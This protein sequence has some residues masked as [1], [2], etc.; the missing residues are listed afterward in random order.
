[1]TITADITA[2]R[3]KERKKGF[4][5]RSILN[6]IIRSGVIGLV[7]FSPLAFGSVHTWAFTTI[8]IIILVLYLLWTIRSFHGK[9]GELQGLK[10]IK[11]PLNLPI[12]LFIG[13]V[14]FQLCPLPSS[15]LKIISPTTYRLY[16]SVFPNQLRDFWTLSIYPW[17]TAQE[18]YR[19]LAYVGAFYLV[20]YHFR[21]KVWLDRLI[22]AI[23]VTGFVAATLGILQHF[24]TPKEIYGFRDASYAGPFGPYVNRNHFAGYME[25][26]ILSGI[27]LLLSQVLVLRTLGERW[28]VYLSEWGERVFKVALVGFSVTVMIV[29]LALSLSR[30]GIISL[31]VALLFMANM[32]LIRQRGPF[33]GVLGL[34]LAFA[35]FYLLWLGIDPVVRQLATLKH[36][37]TTMGYRWNTWRDTVDMGK[38]FLSAGTGFGTFKY[39]YPL[40]K[41]MDHPLMFGHTENDYLELFSELGV[42]GWSLFW[43][44]IVVFLLSMLRRWTE[45]RYPYAVGICIGCLTAIVSLLLHS[46]VDFNLHI[47][48]NALLFFVL[49]GIGFNAVFLRAEGKEVKAL[50]PSRE[51]IM[52][53]R[54]RRLSSFLILC[55]FAIYAGAITRSYLAQSAVE[56]IRG[57]VKL[58]TEGRITTWV[59]E[60]V[61]SRLK[62][63]K[64]VS[65]GYALPHYLLGK[66]YEEMALVQ[67][68]PEARWSF[69]E[70][71]AK[72][73]R[74]AIRLQPTYAW[75][76]LGLG[77]IY[78][79]CSER[80]PSLRERAKREFAIAARLAPHNPDVQEYLEKVSIHGL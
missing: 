37:S 32:M 59:D 21:D 9:H 63:I 3:R 46:A 66:A 77:W 33:F 61:I 78:L 60:D 45:R 49:L 71:A 73:Y 76:H 23:I 65:P 7:V 26:V 74:I 48:A 31:F 56:E 43:G 11:T 50:P 28:R 40:Y 18:L 70:L 2:R 55:G 35:L 30:G 64:D 39:I 10:W 69:L 36:W 22:K 34:L 67:R 62:R 17:A 27:G 4:R 58:Y 24:A 14:L 12:F 38:D 41:T 80:D 6:L 15:L 42:V 25:M 20:V 51:I 47:P 79:I 19:L 44:G 13:F 5:E 75:S 8:E 54:W 53:K 29:A 57:R 72:E 1:M 68:R 16:L 52:S